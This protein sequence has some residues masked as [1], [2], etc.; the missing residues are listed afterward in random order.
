MEILFTIFSTVT[1][2]FKAKPEVMMLLGRFLLLGLSST[3]PLNNR[4]QIAVNCCCSLQKLSVPCLNCSS[5]GCEV[6]CGPRTSLCQEASLSLENNENWK[7]Y[8]RL[9]LYFFLF[10]GCLRWECLL[11][12][13]CQDKQSAGLGLGGRTSSDSSQHWWWPDSKEQ[14]IIRS[15][16]SASC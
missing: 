15:S 7:V 2:H 1:F 8:W 4:L 11:G 3:S 12:K 13:K 10:L 16:V 14:K 6:A 9:W 5:S